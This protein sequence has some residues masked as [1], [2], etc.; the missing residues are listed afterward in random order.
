MTDDMDL[1][2]D[3]ITSLATFLNIEDLQSTA[4]FPQHM[5]RLREIL[6]KV[7][8]VQLGTG[9]SRWLMYWTYYWSRCHRCTI[10][11]GG[12]VPLD[13]SEA[14]SRDGWPLESH[15]QPRGARRGRPA[16][17]RHVST[18]VPV[19]TNTAPSVESQFIIPTVIYFDVTW[20]VAGR[21]CAK[22]TW[23][24]L[25]SIVTSSTATRFAPITTRSCSTV[26]SRSTSW[27]REPA[28]SEVIRGVMLV[29][30][31]ASVQCW[32]V[33]CDKPIACLNNACNCQISWTW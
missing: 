33:A 14:D 13:A 4:E 1:A 5:E 15:P 10:Y 31:A 16:D 8:A 12:R 3:V 11:S 22:V 2:G 9:Q 6:I 7:S 24:Y 17:G 26:S 23:S 28:S 19:H 18:V 25:T 21:T 30:I 29:S 20:L 32:A 27:S